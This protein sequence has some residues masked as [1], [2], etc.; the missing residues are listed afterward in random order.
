MFR[1]KH[2]YPEDT[3]DLYQRTAAVIM[4]SALCSSQDSDPQS[5]HPAHDFNIVRGLVPVKGFFFMSSQR[6][7]PCICH[8]WFA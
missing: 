4:K 2:G 7:F 5:A 3:V 6:V 8:F 1:T